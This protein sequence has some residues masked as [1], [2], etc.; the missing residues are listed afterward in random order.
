M[1]SGRPRPSFITSSR[2][3]QGQ[4]AGL[5]FAAGEPPRVGGGGI[6]VE[7]LPDLQRQGTASAATTVV[8]GM[9]SVRRRRP[10]PLFTD[11]GF[12][13]AL[14]GLARDEAFEAADDLARGLAFRCA[15]RNEVDGACVTGGVSAPGLLRNVTGS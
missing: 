8:I 5:L 4:G 7:A 9:A 1:R 12:S 2:V 11:S 13:D 6:G 10:V 3:G 14:E 15:S